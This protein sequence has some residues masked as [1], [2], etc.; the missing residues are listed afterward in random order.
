MSKLRKVQMRFEQTADGWLDTQTGLVWKRFD[1]PN[2]YT[3]EEALAL[4]DDTW[5]LPTI[6]ELFNIVDVS[7]YKPA[8][9]MP[10]IECAEY[11]SSSIFA[12]DNDR[13]WYVDFIFGNAIYYYNYCELQ[14]R[15]V[16]K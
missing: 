5:R 8:T 15:L 12:N 6:N 7:K 14:V 13:S 2:S 1:E 10:G 16:K 11:W 9:T 4:Q 3:Y